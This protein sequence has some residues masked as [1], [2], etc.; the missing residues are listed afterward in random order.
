M[1]APLSFRTQD[2]VEQGGRAAVV[3]V[4]A[5]SLFAETLRG[6]VPAGPVKAAVEF[7]VGTEDVLVTASVSGAWRLACARCLTEHDAPYSASFEETYPSSAEEID[8]SEPVRE[9]ALLEVPSRSLCRPDCRGLCTRCGKNLNEGPC[10]CPPEKA[11][12]FDV[13]KRLKE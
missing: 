6:A 4:P 5:D 7:S 12:T 10:G 1:S 2:I 13:L 3:S 8:L 9:T 11:A